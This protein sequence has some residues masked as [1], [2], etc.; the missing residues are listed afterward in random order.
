MLTGGHINSTEYNLHALRQLI[1]LLTQPKSGKGY[2]SCCI[3]LYS[4]QAVRVC[5]ALHISAEFD[6]LCGVNYSLLLL[7]VGNRVSVF[8]ALTGLWAELSGVRF[9]KEGKLFSKVLRPTV[10]STR[11][12]FL[13]DAGSA[14]VKKVWHYYYASL[15]AFLA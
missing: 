12:F 4:P 15:C 11:P 3:L 2:N 10:G 13:M 7:D 14:E 6:T 1:F 8:S 9:P 5:A